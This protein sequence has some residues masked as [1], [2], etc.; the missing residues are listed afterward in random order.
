MKKIIERINQ[1]IRL[2]ESASED[3]PNEAR[4]AALQ[5]CR[6]I[7]KHGLEVSEPRTAYAKVGQSSA[8]VV[9]KVI[10]DVAKEAAAR[11]TVN[12]VV[13]VLGRVVRRGR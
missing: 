13:D 11:I 1:L 2:S 7:V 12:D 3:A 4:A 8:E 10:H 9:G 5:A 6:L